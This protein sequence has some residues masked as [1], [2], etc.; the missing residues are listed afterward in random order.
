MKSPAQSVPVFSPVRRGTNALAAVL[1]VL[2]ILAA[3]RNSLS[4][5]LIFDDE[6]AILQNRMIR[7]LWPPWPAWLPP[8]DMTVTGRP[9][10]NFTLAVNYAISGTQV[11]S[12][13]ALNVLI[14]G[15]GALTLFG[16][17]RRTLVLVGSRGQGARSRAIDGDRRRETGGG[18]VSTG[19]RSPASS[20]PGAD[21]TLL[22][23]A[24]ALLWGL[25]PLQVEAVTYVIQ[26]VES[27]MAL[28]FLLVFYC[29]LRSLDSPHGRLWR[30]GAVAACLL[31]AA[32]KEVIAVAPVL[33]LFF[34]RTFVAGSFRAAWRERRGLY[35]A[36]AGTW[37]FLA[38]MVASAGWNRNGTSGFDI[39]VTPSSYWLTQ[40]EAVVRYLGLSVWPHP[41]VFEYGTF[42]GRL[43]A[44][45]PY[46]LVLIPLVVTVLVALWQR[47][48]LG[49]LGAWF[50][51]ILA[52][53]SVMPGRIQMIVEHRMYLPL[54]AVIVLLAG[55]V[56]R[57]CGRRGLMALLAAAAGL[58]WLAAERNEVYRTAESLWRD[59]IARRPDN[60]RAHNCLGVVL[61]DAGRL[62]EAIRSYRTALRLRPRFPEAHNNLGYAL[63]KAGQ[64]PEAI[65][66][67]EVALRMEPAYAIAHIN[68]GN[69]LLQAGRISEALSHYEAALR[70]KGDDP[71][72]LY[73]LGNALLAAGR[74]PEAIERYRAARR[75][76]PDNAEIPYNLGNALFQDGRLDEAAAAYREAL[77]LAPRFAQA[78]SNLGNA[79]LQ[80]Q[81]TP[82]AIGEFQDA[83]RIDPNYAEGHNNLGAA[84]C[85]AGRIPEAIREFETALRLNPRYDD[86]RRN[87]ERMRDLPPGG[88]EKR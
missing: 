36:L 22:A 3:Y 9:L 2:G 17:V 57:H 47:P 45:W 44:A 16:V 51:G 38:A 65:A 53:T 27:L 35:L 48:V 64:L 29:F 83:L 46:A 76:D 79:L 68:L 63:T 77:Q 39:G 58:G 54:A 59:T 73:N 8:G 11:W 81:R 7:H 28:F 24:V 69:A 26:R 74:I 33:L 18:R 14:H 10:A 55:L 40:F 15:L 85:Q 80:L 42:W 49:F 84:Y 66:E 23:L 52:P 78:H 82:E 56:A 43:A 88:G 32:T 75:Q 41:L 61:F 34:D 5:A 72:A 13:H 20:L 62:P 31:G 60:E 87:L 12:Y 21:A 67:L 30:A 50:F 37:V 70:I 71:M 6:P 19:L 86:A 4:G 1:I 25:H